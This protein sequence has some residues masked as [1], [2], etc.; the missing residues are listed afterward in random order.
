MNIL[1][2]W[3]NARKTIYVAVILLIVILVSFG[4]VKFEDAREILLLLGISTVG[5]GVVAVANVEKTDD[6][7]LEDEDE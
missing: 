6:S 4:W 1:K 5:S 7:W 3:P 2:E